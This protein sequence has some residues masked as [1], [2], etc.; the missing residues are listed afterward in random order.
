MTPGVG[1]PFF[2]ARLERKDPKADGVFVSRQPDWSAS[3]RHCIGTR[4]ADF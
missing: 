3:L 1:A 2:L 4:A